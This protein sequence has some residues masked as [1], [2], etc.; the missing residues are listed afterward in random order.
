MVNRCKM[1]LL[2][3]FF[4]QADIPDYDKAAD[5]TSKMLKVQPKNG[6]LIILQKQLSQLRGGSVGAKVRRFSGPKWGGGTVTEANGN[7]RIEAPYG[8]YLMRITFIGYEP[9]YYPLISVSEISL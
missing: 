9:T 6:A 4:I 5:L 7:F 2:R 8:T 1:F 3:K